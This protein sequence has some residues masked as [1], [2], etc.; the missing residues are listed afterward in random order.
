MLKPKNVD[1]PMFDTINI[2][3][4]KT[5]V[6]WGRWGSVNIRYAKNKGKLGEVNNGGAETK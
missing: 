4:V 6:H 1:Q 2:G 3:D 5:K